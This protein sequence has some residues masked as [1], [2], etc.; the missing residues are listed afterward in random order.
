MTLFD[1][2]TLGVCFNPLPPLPK[3]GGW[4]GGGCGKQTSIFKTND[5]TV[6]NLWKIHFCFSFLYTIYVGIPLR[7]YVCIIPIIC[8]G[9]RKRRGECDSPEKIYTYMSS[10]KC[11]YFI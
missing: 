8:T 11:A 2:I 6:V 3:K 5:T 1:F 4:G 7:M 9:V 10:L